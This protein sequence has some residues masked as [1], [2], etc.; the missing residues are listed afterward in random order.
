MREELGVNRYLAIEGEIGKHPLKAAQGRD[1]VPRQD[2][3]ARIA[4]EIRFAGV[5]HP[6]PFWGPRGPGQPF[7]GKYIS[8]PFNGNG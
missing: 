6:I 5:K 8:F 1:V 2:L 7:S 3:T 4:E